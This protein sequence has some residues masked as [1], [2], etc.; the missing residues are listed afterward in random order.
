MYSDNDRMSYN[1]IEVVAN[2][3]DVSDQLFLKLI[4]TYLQLLSIINRL[5][6]EMV[7]K[8]IAIY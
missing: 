6:S 1:K 7:L 5:D 2:V 4:A 8:G 3:D